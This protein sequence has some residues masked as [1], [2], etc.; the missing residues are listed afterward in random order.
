MLTQEKKRRVAKWIRFARE[1]HRKSP[2]AKNREK[3]NREQFSHA[4][5]RVQ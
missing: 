4:N 3:K 5:D 2:S 1:K